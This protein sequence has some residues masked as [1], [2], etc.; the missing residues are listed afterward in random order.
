MVD[1]I[2]P[3]PAFELHYA[4]FEDAVNLLEEVGRR[5]EGE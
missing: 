3:L 2:A 1:S 5:G 4:D